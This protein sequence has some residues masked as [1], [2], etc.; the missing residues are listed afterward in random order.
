MDPQASDFEERK[1]KCCDRFRHFREFLSSSQRQKVIRWAQSQITEHKFERKKD[2]KV[3]LD[4]AIGE[5]KLRGPNACWMNRDKLQIL[6]RL[7]VANMI[8]EEMSTLLIFNAVVA[9]ISTT[10]LQPASSL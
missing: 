2:G 6:R 7:I 9:M 5:R 3:E 10:A 8:L 1:V 4:P